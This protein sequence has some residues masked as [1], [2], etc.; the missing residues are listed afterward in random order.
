MVS[1]AA[2]GFKSGLKEPS[3]K[4]IGKMEKQMVPVGSSMLM[5]ML[6]QA[7]GRMTELMAKDSISISMVR[8]MKVNG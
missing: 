8:Y 6:T 7:N 2:M 3:M 1:A 5:A 4:E